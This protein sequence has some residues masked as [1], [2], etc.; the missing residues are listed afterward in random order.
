MGRRLKLRDAARLSQ[1]HTVSQRGRGGPDACG[2]S[3]GRFSLCRTAPGKGR[4]GSGQPPG[5]GRPYATSV[6][7][8]PV[9]GTQ[10]PSWPTWA[11]W[12]DRAGSTFSVR[13]VC[14]AWVWEGFWELNQQRLLQH[15]SGARHS[16]ATGQEG[17]AEGT[18]RDQ[19]VMTRLNHQGARARRAK[20]R[21][22]LWW[23]AAR[24][25]ACV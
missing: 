16:G 12:Q 22:G 7:P 18:G 21:E 1:G 15:E 17:G 9:P 11:A 4:V 2:P 25:R 3:G 19:P 6:L 5:F 8:A 20:P 13:Q 14:R 24:A 10:P 23:K